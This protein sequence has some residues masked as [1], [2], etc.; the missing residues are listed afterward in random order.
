MFLYNSDCN[1]VLLSK[2]FP[3]VSYEE[4]KRGLCILD[5]YGLHL[6]WEVIKTAAEMRSVE[7]FLNF[8]VMD[9][10]MNVLWRSG[11]EHVDP[12]QAQRMTAFWGDESWKEVGYRSDLGLFGEIRTKAD[13]E[14]IAMAFQ[15]RLR[16]T[17][18]FEYVPKPVPMRNTK[19]AT[20]YYLFF[21]CQKPVALKIV[22]EI[23]DKYG[24]LST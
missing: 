14:T 12:Y 9:M 4:Y 24:K 16:K 11:Q 5:P 3:R 17:A 10:N 1:E 19:G 22:R 23:F 6:D 20:V 21:A 18:G 8:P 13:N 7:I 15:K 2:V